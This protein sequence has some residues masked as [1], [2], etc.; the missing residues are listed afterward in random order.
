MKQK[1]VDKDPRRIRA[2]FAG[3]ARRYDAL[4]HLLSLNVDRSWRRT[5]AR[6][7]D[8]RPGER[9][10]DLCTGTA[11]LALE[12]SRPGV[13]GAG[14]PVIGTDFC[15]EMLRI[16][17]GKRRRRSAPVRLAAAD[18]L[19]L[20]F[21]ASSF[22]AA[23]VAFGIRNLAD[24][25]LG[26]REILRVLRPGGRAAILE[27]TTPTLPGF[28]SLFGFYFHRVLPR[29]GRLVARSRDPVAGRA[30][31]YLPDSVRQFPDADGLAAAMTRAGFVKVTYRRL[32]MG[33]ACIHLG[34][35]RG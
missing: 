29:L 23:S 33:I 3:I 31:S 27:F 10:L 19:R 8:P 34:E 11:D 22:N 25:D 5:A 32:T 26:L 17:E 13:G 1:A 9:L 20:P 24:L 18:A 2:M 4:N 6:L 15:P 35:K 12:L 14:T 28:R 16:G 30:Y 7:I 21:A